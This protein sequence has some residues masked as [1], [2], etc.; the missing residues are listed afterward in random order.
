MKKIKLKE[1][2]EELELNDEQK[3]FI[4]FYKKSEELS[5]NVSEIKKELLNKTV[6]LIQHH[7][8]GKDNNYN[9]YRF[10]LD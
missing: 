3:V 2:I 4:R 10:I 6:K 5:M 8:G 7:Y 1:V 9:C